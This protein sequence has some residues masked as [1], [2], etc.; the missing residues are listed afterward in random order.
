[1]EEAAGEVAGGV[2]GEVEEER[3]SGAVSIRTAGVSATPRSANWLRQ[4]PPLVR[5]TGLAKGLASIVVL[6]IMY[7]P[8]VLLPKRTS[9]VYNK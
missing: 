7:K 2:E 9:I 4:F 8:N 1:M 6:E 5:T 3:V